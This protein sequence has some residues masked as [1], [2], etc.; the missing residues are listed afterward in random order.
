M[1]K[2]VISLCVLLLMLA[3]FT[4]GTV[5]PRGDVDQNGVVDIKDVVTLIDYLLT[6]TWPNDTVEPMG[7]TCPLCD[8]VRF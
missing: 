1:K 8:F 6:E 4:A 2:L 3:S 5:Y 7:E